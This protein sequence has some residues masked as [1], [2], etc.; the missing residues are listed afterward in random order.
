MF[1]VAF[2]QKR[3]SLFVVRE[4]YF[5]V[6]FVALVASG[7]GAYGI[8]RYR[9]DDVDAALVLLPGNSLPE[10]V[11]GALGAAIDL[12]VRLADHLSGGSPDTDAER[13][14]RAR[15]EGERAELRLDDM[16]RLSAEYELYRQREFSPE[17]DAK[18]GGICAPDT[19]EATDV[20]RCLS[21]TR[22]ALIA[23]R[24][25]RTDSRAIFEHFYG[26][27]RVLWGF[28]IAVALFW[29]YRAFRQ[30]RSKRAALG[31]PP[32]ATPPV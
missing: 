19:P 26:W 27:S 6:V 25:E 16:E 24:E 10:A 23:L 12:T 32:A 7:I 4:T 22:E 29:L 17:V 30:M 5:A 8:H 2:A 1:A 20:F 13:E 11:V 9:T 18:I 3:G 21:L 15:R 28:G 31:E 14:Q